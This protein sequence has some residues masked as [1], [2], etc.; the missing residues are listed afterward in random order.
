MRSFWVILIC[1]FA[2]LQYKL[3]FG[4]GSIHQWLE[5]EHKNIIQEELNQKLTE[6]N[7]VLANEIKDLKSGKQALEEKARTDL[8]MIKDDETYYQ[9]VD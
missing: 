3:W 9:L 7:Q 6:R 4:D 2:G 1:A 8:G 5:L